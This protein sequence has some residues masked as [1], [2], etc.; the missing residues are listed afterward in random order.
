MI[1]YNTTLV[2][3]IV[4]LIL[5]KYKNTAKQGRRYGGA[6][7]H[8]LPHQGRVALRQGILSIFVGDSD[9]SRRKKPV[10]VIH[11]L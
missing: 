1:Y 11:C 6:R 2:V 10:S 8:V 4:F 7:G 5:L 9:R 3:C